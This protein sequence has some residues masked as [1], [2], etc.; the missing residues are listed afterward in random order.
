MAYQIIVLPSAEADLKQMDAPVRRSVLRRL[1]WLHDNAGQI[2]HHRLANLPE[3]LA[4]LCRLRT[5][6]YRI[7]YWSYPNR[8]LLKVY[9][10]QHRR[11]VYENL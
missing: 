1:V 6:D 11:E 9:R 7:L 4:G 8:S 10:I 3:D 5:G 2:I